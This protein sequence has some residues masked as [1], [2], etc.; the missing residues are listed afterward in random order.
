MLLSAACVLAIAGCGVGNESQAHV[1]SS[2]EVPSGILDRS[3]VST[4]T[5]GGTTT[6]LAPMTTYRLFFVKQPGYLFEV[7]R[8]SVGVPT[9]AAVVDALTQGP[10][11]SEFAQGYRNPL[12]N[13]NVVSSVRADGALARV[14]LARSFTDIPRSDQALAIGQL[15]L[16]LT[17]RPDVAR[18]LFTQLN[19]TIDVPKGDTSLTHDPVS[20]DDF[21]ALVKIPAPPTTVGA[22]GAT[23][24]SGATG[25]SGPT[26]GAGATGGS[27]ATGATGASLSSG[28]HVARSPGATGA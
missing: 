26:G 15:T 24:E 22:T 17:D 19:L 28:A 25:G 4:T 11:T 21:K 18:V 14:D 10:T 23:G 3:F 9:L 7:T 5:G 20:A 12:G 6:T 1:F 2:D 16:T 8:T 13:A 27:G